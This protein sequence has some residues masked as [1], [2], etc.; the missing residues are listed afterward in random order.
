MEYLFILNR[1]QAFIQRTDSW[2]CFIPTPRSKSWLRHD[3][4]CVFYG[5]CELSSHWG[6][7]GRMETTQC[8]SPAAVWSRYMGRRRVNQRSDRASAQLGSSVITGSDRCF[9]DKNPHRSVGGTNR[10]PAVSIARPWCR[11]LQKENASPTITAAEPLFKAWHKS[12][13]VQVIF[14]FLLSFLFF[15]LT[16]ILTG[17]FLFPAWLC[18]PF[19]LVVGREL[20]VKK[21]P[22]SLPLPHKKKPLGSSI[23]VLVLLELRC[24]RVCFTMMLGPL[25]PDVSHSWENL[26]SA[27]IYQSPAVGR[28]NDTQACDNAPH[29]IQMC[30][31]YTY[32]YFMME[33]SWVIIRSTLQICRCFYL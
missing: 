23:G 21:F 22:L 28:P 7:F 3:T 26:N 6:A 33:L 4:D 14:F 15:L 16:Y 17:R 30:I 9:L 18:R 8:G 24:S 1:L 31:I 2:N 20:S 10:R 5:L 32:I 19:A 29:H 13:L 12:F 25:Q 11:R 27:P